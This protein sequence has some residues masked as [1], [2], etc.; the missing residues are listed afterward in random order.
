MYT[1]FPELS[2]FQPHQTPPLSNVDE[3]CRFQRFGLLDGI[4]DIFSDITFDTREGKAKCELFE[5]AIIHDWGKEPTSS[6]SR[7]KLEQP[8]PTAP[9]K[10]TT[11]VSKENPSKEVRLCYRYSVTKI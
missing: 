6:V 9:S 1:I 3:K 11:T 5:L 7:S 2:L 4:Y 8:S 10:H